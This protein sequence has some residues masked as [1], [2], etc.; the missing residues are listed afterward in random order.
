MWFNIFF[1]TSY[2]PHVEDVRAVKLGVYD[3]RQQL[4]CS[5]NMSDRYSGVPGFESPSG[6]RL[7]SLRIF[8]VFLN[9]CMQVTEE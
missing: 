6:E 1:V 8:M 7:S 9:L 4:R 5:S 3:V 2:M